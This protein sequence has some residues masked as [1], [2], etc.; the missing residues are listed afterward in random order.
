[1]YFS[2]FSTLAVSKYTA[3]EG[4]GCSEK[5]HADKSMNIQYNS[6]TQTEV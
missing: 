6:Q 2:V 3:K 5:D 4:R 1:M